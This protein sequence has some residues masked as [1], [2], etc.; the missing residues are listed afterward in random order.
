MFL[1]VFEI[2]ATASGEVLNGTQ[3]SRRMFWGPLWAPRMLG[4]SSGHHPG[5]P[6]NLH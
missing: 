4:G 3:S 5:L 6:S 1:N 2:Y